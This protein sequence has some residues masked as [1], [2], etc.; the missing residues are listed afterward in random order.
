[1][2]VTALLAEHPPQLR[3][4]GDPTGGRE[5]LGDLLDGELA[6]GALVDL[7]RG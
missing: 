1:M 2:Q 6:Q 4:Q 5:S 3:G 7:F